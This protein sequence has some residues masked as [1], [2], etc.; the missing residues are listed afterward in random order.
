MSR[1]VRFD[2]NY[3]RFTNCICMLKSLLSPPHLHKF[4][5]NSFPAEIGQHR[6]TTMSLNCV[7]TKRWEVNIKLYGWAGSSCNTS[8]SFA[9][10]RIQVNCGLNIEV[11]VLPGFFCL[12]FGELVSAA[13][14]KSSDPGNQDI[15]PDGSHVFHLTFPAEWKSLTNFQ[16]FPKSK[17]HWSLESVMKNETKKTI[18]E[19]EVDWL[20]YVHHNKRRQIEAKFSNLTAAVRKQR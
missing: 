14:Q 7:E 2:M 9:R 11:K 6:Q 18:A 4:A 12:K 16:D 3:F 20:V 15:V 19:P 8:W 17:K 10:L 13:E 5:C 1:Q